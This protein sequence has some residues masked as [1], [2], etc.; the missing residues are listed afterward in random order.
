MLSMLIIAMADDCF[1]IRY[2]LDHDRIG[3]DFD[4]VADGDR[5]QDGGPC[6]NHHSVL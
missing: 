3:S 5:A 1:T 4:I 6:P 2:V